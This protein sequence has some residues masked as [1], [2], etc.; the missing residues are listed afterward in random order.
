[1]TT[2][3]PIPI[4]GVQAGVGPNNQ[5][6]QRLEINDHLSNS[7]R[8]NL[9]LL[10]LERM[11]GY[12]T[13][14]LKSWFQVCGIHGRPYT[15][16]NGEGDGQGRKPGG[17][18]THS[19]VLFLTWHRPYLALYEQVLY[20][21][22]QKVVSEFPEPKRSQLDKVAKTFRIPYWD[23]AAQAQ[24]HPLILTKN[25]EVEKPKGKVTIPN[26][27]YS[28]KFRNSE[29][30][31]FQPGRYRNWTQTIRRPAGPD[32]QQSS[33]N[34]L[35]NLQNL[36]E[37]KDWIEI[38]DRFGGR[39]GAHF[40]LRERI[41][42]LLNLEQNRYPTYQAFSNN[43]WVSNGR[44]SDYDSL[45]SVHDSF[46]GILGGSGHMGNP[47][48]AGFDPIFWLHHCNVDRLYAIWQGLHWQA[49]M[50]WNFDIKEETPDNPLWWVKDAKKLETTDTPLVPFRKDNTT[51]WDSNT[52]RD[53]KAFGYTYPELV[54]WNVPGVSRQQLADTVSGHIKRLYGAQT[55]AGARAGIVSAAAAQI[56]LI[57]MP[58]V[59]PAEAHV[60]VAAA[61]PVAVQNVQVPLGVQST[62]PTVA[63]VG[64]QSVSVS[65]TAA[66]PPKPCREYFANMRAFKYDFNGPFAVHVFLGKFSPDP[67]VREFDP[68]LV[69]SW[70][71]FASDIA[72]TGCA[73]CKKGAEMG[74]MVTGAVPLTS[75]LEE[76]VGRGVESMELEHVV[77]YLTQNLHWRIH[78]TDADHTNID[79]ASVNEKLRFAVT[80]AVASYDP[81]SH[82]VVYTDWNPI[83][84]I[85]QG[86]PTGCGPDDAEGYEG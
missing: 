16:Y 61:P 52:S 27:L 71:V 50:N 73:N 59:Q 20:E 3:N 56:N 48:Y 77:P 79:R 19:S 63:S 1:M 13:T 49:D 64:T 28:Y 24:I 36:Q 51:Y 66:G 30:Q 55:S 12:D 43:K 78:R 74:L 11:Q 31:L 47:G 22:I 83:P 14:D 69:G 26:P 39:R 65:T 44:S 17:Y 60:S 68:N 46:H 67:K 37:F 18:C 81:T 34:Q 4:T 33:D 58:S 76:R 85:T 41:W 62:P 70:H 54:D 84:E 9:L 21:H 7:D 5:T 10:G 57:A 42:Y 72:T 35:T 53:F 75:A 86:R 40:N 82:L 38:D 80:S 6:P 25:V 45:E 32:S 15:P 8:K 29:L 23:W 2:P